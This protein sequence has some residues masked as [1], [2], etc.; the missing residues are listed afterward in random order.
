MKTSGKKNKPARNVK[1]VLLKL[2]LGVSIV[3]SVLVVSNCDLLTNFL[4]DLHGNGGPPPPDFG[5]SES[6][7]LVTSLL[8]PLQK[9]LPV[10]M[11]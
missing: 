2:F 9:M 6:G 11:A 3:F 4:D 10:N 7:S 8:K 5:G 1:D